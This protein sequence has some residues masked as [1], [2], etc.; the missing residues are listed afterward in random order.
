MYGTLDVSTS[1]LTAYRTRLDAT[2]ANIAMR[3]AMHL[4]NG[5]FTPYRRRAVLFAQGDPRR[6]D[7]VNGVHVA[8][9]VEDPAPFGKRWDPTHPHAVREGQDKGYVRVSNVDY[10]TEMVDAMT[11]MRA[12]EA[13]VTVMQ[14]AKSM[15]STTLRLIA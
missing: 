6:G 10:H 9:I 14:M 2:A 3:D 7:R 4:E 8:K 15:A 5:E 12:Y 11:A 13:N 1:A